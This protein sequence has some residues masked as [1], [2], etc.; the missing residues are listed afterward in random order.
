MK[1]KGVFYSLLVMMLW[2]F[3]FPTVKKGYA[4]FGAENAGDFLTFAGVRF[5]ICGAV[6]CVYALAKNKSN[7]KALKGTMVLVLLVGLFAIVLHY[8][9][10]Y[11]A[12]SLTDGSK[13]AILKQ[14]GAVF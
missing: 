3:L 2:G 4:V 11:I 7:F 14:L 12:L 9:C 6:I 8:S 5:L 10:T 13:T 1:N